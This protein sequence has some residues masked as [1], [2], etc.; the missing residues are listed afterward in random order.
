MIESIKFILIVY[1]YFSDNDSASNSAAAN[2]NK[3]SLVPTETFAKKAIR[4]EERETNM[5][6]NAA[7]DC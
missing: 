1:F 6:E 5:D 2:R 4:N 7:S 3:A